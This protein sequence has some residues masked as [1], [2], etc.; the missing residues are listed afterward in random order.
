MLAFREIGRDT[1]QDIWILPF[2]GDEASGWKPGK[3][4]LLLGGPSNESDVAFSP[5]GRWITFQSDESG[6]NEVYV[7]P[8]PGPGARTQVSASGGL[9]PRWS[10]KGQK[11]FYRTDDGKIMIATYSA[12]G[13]SFRA[14]K[15]SVWSEG[16]VVAFDVHPDGQRLAVLKTA[17]SQPQASGRFVLI[18]NFFEELR[19]VSK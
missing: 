8:F 11:L 14:D 12:A 2:D 7:R 9:S 13:D 4:T 16:P 5:D 15:P 1:G 18:L 6:R 17:A 19:R 3:P 10:P